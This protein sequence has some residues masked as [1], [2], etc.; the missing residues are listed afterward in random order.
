MKPQL[1]F[2][3]GYIYNNMM[4]AAAGLVM[5]NVANKSWEDI[6]RERILKP[7]QMTAS[8]FSNDDMK[9]HGNYS[10]S[11]FEPD[12]TRRLLAKR[13]EAQSDAL[14]PAGTLKSTV[15]DMSHWMIAQLNGG[16]YNGKQVMSKKS[17]AETM[18][19]N[20]ISDREGKYD[21]L[22]NGLYGLG[23]IVQ[24]YKG[25]KI[26]AHTGSIDGFYSSLV[27]VPGQ[28][29][30]V[31]MVHNGERGSSIRSVMALPVLDKLLGLS[32]TPWSQRYLEDFNKNRVASKR[33][34]DSVKATQV[35]GSTTSHPLSSYAGVYVSPVYGTIKMEHLNDG[36][37]MSFRKVQSPLSHFHY[38]QF[39]TK[40]E[41][42]DLP[43]FRLNFLTNDKGE[44]DRFSTRVFGD[45][46]ELFIRKPEQSPGSNLQQER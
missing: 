10:L 18:M 30:G 19:P 9:K 11:Y 7:L 34:T 17:I 20:A 4:Y 44:I 5:E 29:L 13:Y 6:I 33:A 42:T 24:T 2:R 22:S 12:S 3:E 38:D 1:G 37:I 23:R 8:V 32:Y 45:P 46:V 16:M 14:G 40:D 31:F 43:K 21:E 28:Q 26:A 41:Q 35:K 39:T 27:F 36:L 15:E 25:Y